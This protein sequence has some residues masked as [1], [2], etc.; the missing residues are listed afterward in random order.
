M[1][2]KL[3]AI[4]GWIRHKLK[5]LRL[6]QCK[7]TTGIVRWLRKL[8]VE[9]TLSWR[10]ALSGKGWWRL[11]NSAALNIGMNKTWFT[12]QGCYSLNENYKSL[13]R[14]SL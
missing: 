13:H 9:E 7:R 4:A 1:Q 11:S 5:C 6:K 3:T 2:S 12:Q 14:K 10:T 8:G